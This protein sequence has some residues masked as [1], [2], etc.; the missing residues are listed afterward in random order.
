VRGLLE[1]RGPRRAAAIG[2]GLTDPRSFAENACDLIAELSSDGRLLY[3]NPSVETH[4][5][6]AAKELAGRRVFEFVH[7]DHL[8]RTLES[9]REAVE[10][11]SAS[12]GAHRVRHRDGSWRW[13][14]STGNPYRTADGE[15]RVIVISRDV[16]E[17]FERDEEPG[18]VTPA[19]STELPRETQISD[20]SK[21]APEEAG[22]E[23]ILLVED[24]D[25]L[26]S[27]VRE[28]LEEE[29]YAVLQA[30]SGEEALERTANHAGPIHLVLS[31]VVMPGID[32]QEL[33]QRLGASRPRTRVI[34]MSDY[35]G[36]GA[37]PLPKGM[38]P[39]DFLRKPFTLAALRAKLR[40]ILE[41]DPDRLESG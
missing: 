8:P 41:E 17:R 22:P 15:R 21:V 2:S 29:G 24:D 38:R 6:Y 31:E 28:T 14:E 1:T 13:L 16:T 39:A 23:T 4:L 10:T 33:A 40:E 20:P 35:A 34:L 27:V 5:G 11:G 37:E 19:L 36:D 9:L 25:R 30:A 18:A 7:P 12:R 32:G 26:R 3:V